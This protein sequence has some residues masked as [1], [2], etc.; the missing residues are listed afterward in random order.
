MTLFEGDRKGH[1]VTNLS[2]NCEKCNDDFHNLGGLKKHLR[3]VHDVRKLVFRREIRNL[4]L[5]VKKEV[6]HLNIY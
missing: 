4:L 6:E 1:E 5:N 2:F 3:K